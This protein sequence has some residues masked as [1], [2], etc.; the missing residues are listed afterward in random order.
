MIKLASKKT[1]SSLV[2]EAAVKL[3][4]TLAL[5]GGP[6]GPTPAE[7]RGDPGTAVS[8]LSS[9]SEAQDGALC[10]AIKKEFF[11]EARDKGAA[12]IVLSADLLAEVEADLGRPGQPI[13]RGGKTEPTL[14]VFP[15][16]R[17]LFSVVLGLVGPGFSP[18][19]AVNEPYFKDRASCLLGEGVTFGPNSYVGAGVSVGRDSR[20][21]PG[22]FLDDGVSVGRDCVIHPGAVLRYGVRVGDRCQ[23]HANSV[24]GEDGFGYNQVPSPAT[25]RLIHFKNPHLGGVVIG[26]DVEIGAL[27]AIDR[28]LVADT[29]IGRGTK[30]DNLVQ[31]GHNCQIG[32]DCVVVSQVGAAGHSQV[33]DRAFLLGQCGLSHGAKVGPDAIIS[34][35]SGVLGQVPAGRNVWT[36]TPVKPQREEYAAQ[37][38]V[39]NDLP[40]WR[41]FLKLFLKGQSWEQIRAAMGAEP[42][43]SERPKG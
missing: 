12:A 11:L 10:F 17:L 1:L 27:T 15:E 42:R 18:P 21:G 3:S 26:D 24:I 2:E 9:A 37:I 14:V 43:P 16:P 20:I 28:G 25:G 6:V 34:G 36:G 38:M 30:I 13:D 8:A 31:I 7:I 41:A 39:K 5:L 22:V 32:A 4:E 35:Q 23:I 40:K 29:V 19:W 33:G